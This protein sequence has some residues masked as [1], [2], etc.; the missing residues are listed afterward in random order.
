MITDVCTYMTRPW[1]KMYHRSADGDYVILKLDRNIQ[2]YTGT[3]ADSIKIYIQMS[4][5]M[6][7]RVQYKCTCITTQDLQSTL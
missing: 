1:G 5:H 2:I 6:T 7:Y 4:I 3:G